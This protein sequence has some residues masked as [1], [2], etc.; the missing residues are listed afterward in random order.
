MLHAGSGILDTEK[1]ILRTLPSN[2]DV[3]GKLGIAEICG[4]VPD[5]PSLI[6]RMSRTRAE[7]FH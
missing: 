6:E 1:R 5:I 7:G 3:V 4:V 2:M